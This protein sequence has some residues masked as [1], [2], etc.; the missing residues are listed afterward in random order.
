MELSM[1][2]GDAKGLGRVPEKAPEP[3]KETGLKIE[4]GEDAP[5]FDNMISESNMARQAEIEKEKN[6]AGGDFRLGESKNDREFRQQLEKVTGKKQTLAKNKMERDDYLNLL[7]TQLKYQDPTKPMEHYEMASQMAQFNTVEQ[8]MGVNKLLTDMKKLQNDA[9][10]E[11]LTQYLGKDIELQGNNIKLSPDGKANTVHF[12]LPSNASNVIVEIRNENSKVIKSM[13]MGSLQMGN[14]KVTWDGTNDKGAKQAGGNY[15][16]SILASTEDGKPMTA[17][18]S[19]EAKVEGITDIFSGGK[20]D[21]NVG[22]ADANKIIA[23]RNP[24]VEPPSKPNRSQI[25]AYTQNANQGIKPQDN[26]L[27]DLPKVNESSETNNSLKNLSN[28]KNPDE[29]NLSSNK[30]EDNPLQRNINSANDFNQF[31][32]KANTNSAETPLLN[33]KMETEPPISQTRLDNAP[34][35]RPQPSYQETK[36][37]PKYGGPPEVAGISGRQ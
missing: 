8:L 26:K 13:P 23:I 22:S 12:E 15:T 25:S 3:P 1:F 14:N 20:L 2:I 33:K 30:L 17:K 36:A 7:V 10:A 19:Y 24:A 28:I 31:S 34:K 16:F 6:E 11:K 9:K 18:T 27:L 37:S 21:T 35:T 29:F 4:K 5:N 32:T